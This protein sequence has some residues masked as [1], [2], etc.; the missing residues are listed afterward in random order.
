MKRSAHAGVQGEAHCVVSL[1]DGT[2]AVEAAIAISCT[3]NQAMPLAALT[4]F[5]L[6]K[7]MFRETVD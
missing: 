6:E 3:L 5:R 2:A 7:F 1:D 4:A